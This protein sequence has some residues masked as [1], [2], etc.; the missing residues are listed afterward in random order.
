MKTHKMFSGNTVSVSDE[1][2]EKYIAP[3][4]GIETLTPG[5][6]LETTRDLMEISMHRD[7]TDHESAMLRACDAITNLHATEKELAGR[8]PH[9]VFPEG[10]VALDKLKFTTWSPDT[11]GCKL[12]FMWHRDHPESQRVHVPH[13]SV[14]VC[15]HH[16]GLK[17]HHNPEHHD[18]VHAE[19]V[20][21]N[22]SRH[23]LATELGVD[24]GEI[25]HSYTPDRTL[26][27]HHSKLQE[28]RA[29]PRPKG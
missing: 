11:C 24:P 5:Q 25:T 7:L 12:R 16:Q 15:P 17:G 9:K 14:K 18:A 4:P 3:F 29:V 21:K 2:V 20:H 28:P 13:R 27:L 23:A 22:V 1:F 8:D 19:N 26:H 10:Q 6:V